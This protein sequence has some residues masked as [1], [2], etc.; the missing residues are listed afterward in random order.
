[1]AGHNLIASVDD[2]NSA[3]QA[4]GSKFTV[5]PST[6]TPLIAATGGD[7]PDFTLAPGAPEELVTGPNGKALVSGLD[8]SITVPSPGGAGPLD[9]SDSTV[10]GAFPIEGQEFPTGPS[11]PFG[12]EGTTPPPLTPA[13]LDPSQAARLATPSALTPAVEQEVG[14]ALGQ[15]GG[16]PG[17]TPAKKETPGEIL[18]RNLRAAGL[19]DGQIRL[20]VER[21]KFPESITQALQDENAADRELATVRE[22]TAFEAA[23]FRESAVI[24]DK[25]DDALFQT[26][27]TEVQ[28]RVNSQLDELD[29]LQ[30]KQAALKIKDPWADRSTGNKVLAAL[31]I[32]LGGI[33]A[34]LTGGPNMALQVLEKTLESDLKTQERKRKLLGERIGAQKNIL[35]EARLVLGDMDEARA[36]VRI[37][38]W[39]NVNVVLDGILARGVGNEQQALAKQMKAQVDLKGEELRLAFQQ[40]AQ[41]RAEKEYDLKVKRGVDNALR[42][43]KT[44]D[45]TA[46]IM[47]RSGNPKMIAD[48]A[49]LL[50]DAGAAPKNMSDFAQLNWEL[51]NGKIGPAQYARAQLNLLGQS[52]DSVAGA[53]AADLRL[54]NRLPTPLEV[55]IFELNRASNPVN[56]AIVASGTGAIGG[57]FTPVKDAKKPEPLKPG[58]LVAV[59][60]AVKASL[61]SRAGDADTEANLPTFATDAEVDEAVRKGTIKKGD[62]FIS[63]GDGKTRLVP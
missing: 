50:A 43:A 24:E 12:A 60:K 4:T 56:G 54:S 51:Q 13:P 46:G 28:G 32:A 63:S 15:E 35:E 22:N 23:S 19:T 14:E 52:I 30:R 10:A 7:I 31:L 3:L 57:I 20:G 2:T 8:P 40:T 17:G 58:E 18:L 36:A 53:I 33:G 26:R 48:G 61:Q 45:E 41:V 59:A 49:K 1:M 37:Q 9:F 16:K 21:E 62:R 47:I 34:G 39:D 44:L 42:D 5:P 38:Y 11:P 27:R 29:N 55:Q 25:V 6:E